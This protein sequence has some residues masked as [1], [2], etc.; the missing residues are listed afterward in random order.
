[1]LVSMLAL[2]TRSS[3]YLFTKSWSKAGFSTGRLTAVD[4]IRYPA[5]S[6]CRKASA[7]RRPLRDCGDTSFANAKPASVICLLSSIF[8]LLS[9]VLCLLSFVFALCQCLE[10]GTNHMLIALETILLFPGK[11]IVQLVVCGFVPGILQCNL[12][13]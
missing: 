11:H 8:C 3:C 13:A 2:E 9:S 4:F 10:I 7:A 6:F 12:S 5:S 1:M